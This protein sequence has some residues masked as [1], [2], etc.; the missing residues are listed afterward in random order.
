MNDD[1]EDIDSDASEGAE[2]VLAEEIRRT[3]DRVAGEYTMT[4]AMV[5]GTL[6]V[7]KMELFQ[8]YMDQ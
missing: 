3:I 2:G 8:N 4:L 1:M 5:I 7:L 6:E